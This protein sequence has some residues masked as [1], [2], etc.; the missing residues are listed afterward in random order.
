MNV[1]T[2]L[3]FIA[4]ILITN[5]HF[6]VLYP[7]QFQVLATGG[8]IGNSL[9]FFISGYTLYFSNKES[10]VKWITKRFLRIYIPVWIFGLV[11]SMLLNKWNFQDFIFPNYW[12][13]RAILVFYFIYFVAIKYFKD[14]LSWILIIVLA[15]YLAI[16]FIN[17]HQ[18]WVIEITENKTYLHWYYYFGIMLFGALTAQKNNLRPQNNL[19]TGLNLV[20]WTSIYYVSKFLIFKFNAFEYQFLIPIILFIIC[21]YAYNL[22]LTINLKAEKMKKPIQLIAG[23]TLEIY[24]VQFVIIRTM[25]NLTFPANTLLSIILI[26]I[27]AYALN[28]ISTKLMRIIIQK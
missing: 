13:L 5:S 27:S 18:S 8:T 15:G 24:I 28:F 19:K 12:F 17:T 14:K 16:F 10:F 2:A 9:F 25:A 4:T 1:I 3:K 20:V 26:L 11:V 6:G 21:Y 7:N 22:T 23:L